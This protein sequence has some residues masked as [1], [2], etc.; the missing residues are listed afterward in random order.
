MKLLAL[1]LLALPT[2]AQ[3]P[4]PDT[5]FLQPVSV[6]YSLL[7]KAEDVDLKKVVV[8]YDD[9]VYVLSNQ[10]LYRVLD[11]KLVRDISYRPL[12]DKAPV[13]II[14]QEESGYLYYLYEDQFLTNAHAGK[15]YAYLPDGEYYQLTVN[16]AGDV[17]VAGNQESAL[18]KNGDWIKLNELDTEIQSVQCHDEQFYALTNSGVYQLTGAEWKL[19]HTDE[20]ANC[21][22]FRDD[23]LLIGTDKG[24]YGISLVDATE[25]TSLV[26]RV[27]VPNINSLL[28]SSDG[29]WAATL[30]GAWQ[31]T[32]SSFRYFSSKRWLDQNEVLDIA[33]DSEGDIY[34]LTASGLNK[35]DFQPMTL[36]EKAKY[37][38]K[39]IRQ[40]HIRYGFIAEMRL[41]KPGDITTAEMIDTDNDGLWS[42]FYLGSQ[43]YRYAVTQEP[44]A[45]RNAWEAFEAYERLLSINPL[46]GFPS[47]TFERKDYK[48]ADLDRW[49]PSPDSAWEWKG[50]TSSD[51][52]V[53]Y[54]YVASL[55]DEFLAESN[56]EKQ[57]VADFIDAIVTHVIENDY[58]FVDIDG[59]PTLWGRWNPEYIN[60]YPPTIRDRRLGSLTLIAGLQLAYDLTGK[61]RFKEE[62]YRMMEE[63][64]YLENILIDMNTIA[65]T[66]GYVHEGHDMGSGGWNHSD[67][68]MAFLTYWVIHRHAFNDELK[69]KYEQAIR[70]HWEIEQLEKNAVWNLITYATEGSF[71]RAATLWFLRDYP[72]DLIRYDTKNSHRQDLTKLEP[73]FRNQE[74]VELLPAVERRIIRYNANPFQ[75]DG[76]QGGLREL[77]GAE[78]LLP[79]WMARYLEV[80]SG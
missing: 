19:F 58:Y 21:I 26:S 53:A 79:Y 62:A 22:T 65:P 74:T 32:D 75:L 25:T 18:Y 56:E 80:V 63:H 60:W 29:L 41:T 39:K 38:E 48:V 64:G 24:Y 70:N 69:Q 61:E 67:D 7:D 76:G 17:L 66:P 15:P 57:R 78:Y 71:D 72:L 27:P 68:E 73:N 59:E 30:Q 4:E 55:M 34:L 6:K 40:R 52:F 46:D 11:G 77:T 23:E 28:A 1:L 51:E 12:A 10:G 50:H 8:N 13:D 36:A 35:V 9:I 54:I 37:F 16:R 33:S 20:E 43:A 2:L 5:S 3:S 14:I 47:R 42:A 49:R 44:K 45:R 31:Q